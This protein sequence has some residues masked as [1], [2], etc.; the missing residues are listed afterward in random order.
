MTEDI[1]ERDTKRQYKITLRQFIIYLGFLAILCA[2][3]YIYTCVCF[4]LKC[5]HNL[6]NTSE[7]YGIHYTKTPLDVEV[8]KD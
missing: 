1:D 5:I 7:T 2:G 3:M 8:Y 4:M 6:W